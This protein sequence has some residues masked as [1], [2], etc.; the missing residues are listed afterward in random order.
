[1]ENLRHIRD[2]HSSFSSFN[3]LSDVRTELPVTFI[4]AVLV[5]TSPSSDDQGWNGVKVRCTAYFGLSTFRGEV[6]ML[7]PIFIKTPSPNALRIELWFL[8][9]LTCNSFKK[10]KKN[11]ISP[12]T[13]PNV[14]FDN[15]NYVRVIGVAFAGNLPIWR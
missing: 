3:Y 7:G 4:H 11:I 12:W 9:L 1:M 8:Q 14:T 6:F 5:N 2:H 10:L 15:K 13:F